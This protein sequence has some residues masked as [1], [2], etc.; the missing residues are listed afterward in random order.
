MDRMQ[1]L[2][3]LSDPAFMPDLSIVARLTA[4]I[5]AQKSIILIYQKFIREH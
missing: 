2:E 1:R 5:E 4:F 3:L